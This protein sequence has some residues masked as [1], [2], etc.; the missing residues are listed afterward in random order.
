MRDKVLP[1]IRNLISNG[2]STSFWNDLWLRNGRLFALYGEWAIHNLGLGS[3][4]MVSHFL[5]NGTWNLPPIT[6]ANLLLAWRIAHAEVVPVM[7]FLDVVVWNAEHNENSSL[8]SVG[9]T[10]KKLVIASLDGKPRADS[11]F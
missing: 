3:Q 5:A 2:G 11:D 8:K 10:E 4:V 7:E 6:L 9:T 1:L